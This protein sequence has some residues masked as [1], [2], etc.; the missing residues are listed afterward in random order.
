MCNA[1]IGRQEAP[2]NE[3]WKGPGKKEDTKLSRGLHRFGVSHKDRTP[4]SGDG[5]QHWRVGV[6]VG[7]GGE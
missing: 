6:G 4:E 1:Q 5:D 3:V 7:V 2:R